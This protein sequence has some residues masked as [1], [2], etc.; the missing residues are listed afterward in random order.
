MNPSSIPSVTNYMQQN[1][2]L[3][4][5]PN[6]SFDF[7]QGAWEKPFTPDATLVSTLLS[8]LR[9]GEVDF[10]QAA[11]QLIA[12]GGSRVG[13][14]LMPEPVKQAL[15]KSFGGQSFMYK[16]EGQTG[17][18]N[19]KNYGFIPQTTKNI[20]SRVTGMGASSQLK[21]LQG[22]LPQIPKL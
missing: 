3:P 13:A 15:V 4:A 1:P 5:I 19:E 10:S 18:F 7:G 21:A 8:K 16:P 17:Y 22:R 2:L 20:V 12:S 9:T 11:N 14:G 6:F